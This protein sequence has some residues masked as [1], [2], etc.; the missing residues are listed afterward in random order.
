MQYFTTID[1]YLLDH[2][3]IQGSWPC[4]FQQEKFKKNLN[5]SW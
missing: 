2:G 3:P 4:G 1:S 5:K